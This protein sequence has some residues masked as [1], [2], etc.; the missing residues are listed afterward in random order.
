MTFTSLCC[1]L[2]F[3]SVSSV[4]GALLHVQ[5]S[6]MSAGL[7]LHLGLSS[8]LGHALLHVLRG[9]SIALGL[10]PLVGPWAAGMSQ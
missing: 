2:A 9:C 5:I 7:K 4:L 8:L 3:V 6:N 1:C 10:L